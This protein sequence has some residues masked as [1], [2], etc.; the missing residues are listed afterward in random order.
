[1]I[2]HGIVKSTVR[3]ESFKMDKYSVYICTDIIPFNEEIEG[4]SFEGWSYNM[5]QYDKDEYILVQQCKIDEEI[6]NNQL[7]LCDLYERME[8]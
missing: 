4:E 2:N 6:T 7:A 8:G 3:P 5:V 1:M